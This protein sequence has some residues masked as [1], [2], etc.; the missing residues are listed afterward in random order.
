MSVDHSGHRQRLKNALRENGLASF[1]PHEVIEL[2]LYTAI[3]RRDVNELAHETDARF[4]GVAGLMDAGEDELVSFGLSPN[5]AKTLKAYLECCK[6]YTESAAEQGEFILTRA[7]LD[8]VSHRVRRP[9]A[10]VLA[11]L[12]TG[13][14][15]V[16]VCELPRG[17]AGKIARFTAERALSCDAAGAIIVCDAKTGLREDETNEISAALK[18][19][20]VELCACV[21]IREEEG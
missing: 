6:A 17:D 20:D 16:F 2:M 19:I 9:G 13:Q 21:N 3:P 15:V 8:M 5:A 1:S 7:D 10:R 4:G 11:L 14:E 12:S 18:L